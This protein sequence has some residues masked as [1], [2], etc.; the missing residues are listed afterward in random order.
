VLVEKYG[1]GK[2]PLL[3]VMA[4][5]GHAAEISPLGL[6]QDK[7]VKEVFGILS[8]ARAPCSQRVEDALPCSERVFRALD[9][10]YDSRAPKKPS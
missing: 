7:D 5:L 1:L 10:W 8:T 6:V 4:R 3:D 9:E 2:D